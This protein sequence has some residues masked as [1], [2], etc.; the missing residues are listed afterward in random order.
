M[1]D[2]SAPAQLTLADIEALEAK[3]ST[4]KAN[5]TK[6]VLTPAQ[7][8]AQ[9]ENEIGQYLAN[10]AH[11]AFASSQATAA[12]LARNIQVLAQALAAYTAPAAASVA[13]TAPAKEPAA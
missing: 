3:L 8:V 1:P 12:L 13:P 2:S 11:P 6:V 5:L 9:V 4:A 10:Q 7:M